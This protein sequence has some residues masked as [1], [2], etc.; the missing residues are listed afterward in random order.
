MR[1]LTASINRLLSIPCLFYGNWVEKVLSSRL[2]YNSMDL[3]PKMR[4]RVFPAGHCK[5]GG[6]S[7]LFAVHRREISEIR[8]CRDGQFGYH[9]LG[10]RSWEVKVSSRHP[11]TNR[12][13]CAVLLALRMNDH[14][15]RPILHHEHS[16]CSD[17][18]KYC[19]QSISYRG[20][21]S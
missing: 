6:R 12:H 13:S 15:G 2:L 14:N 5:G 11:P 20:S 9:P 1:V 17:D 8:I 10:P 4:A 18:L 3:H 16:A 7:F 19:D 21:L